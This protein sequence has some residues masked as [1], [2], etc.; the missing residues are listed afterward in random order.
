MRISN[1][2]DLFCLVFPPVSILGLTWKGSR[3]VSC[4][5]A[6]RCPSFCK[7][8]LNSSMCR[9]SWREESPGASAAHVR[10][11]VVCYSNSEVKLSGSSNL[12]FERCV[13]GDSCL[14]LLQSIT[15]FTQFP[16]DDR[17]KLYKVYK[18]HKSTSALDKLL[19]SSWEDSDAFNLFAELPI[20]KT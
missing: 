3:T 5:V 17:F 6:L 18:K 9:P 15:G 7:A 19:R 8:H 16:D 1:E 14:M 2:C 11:G 20:Q 4:Q 13:R 10:I 12:F